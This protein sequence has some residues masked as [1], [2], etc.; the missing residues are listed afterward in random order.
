M[1][2]WIFSDLHTDGDPMELPSVAADAAVIA[3]DVGCGPDVLAWLKARF[4]T[5][6]T[7]Y[8][9]GNHEY[10]G[11]TLPSLR[12]EFEQQTQGSNIHVLENR[13]LVL[14]NVVFLGCTLWTDFEL[15]GRPVEPMKEAAERLNDFR[16]I[17]YVADDD[18][19]KYAARLEPLD[20]HFLHKAS[21]AWLH[22]QFARPRGSKK[23]VVVTHH[24]PSRRSVAERYRDNPLTP[25]FAS[26]LDDLVEH[27]GAALWIH[28]HV[29]DCFD[30]QLG[31]TRVLCNPRGYV[32]IDDAN[33]FDPALVVEV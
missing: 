4:P 24:A 27:S 11:F 8:V 20:T 12:K 14:G 10:Y 5:L 26:A 32:G 28:G 13:R 2:L 23:L 17:R 9:L 31:Q 33:G 22:K 16:R 30:Y 1:R 6:P 15:Y 21:V 7:I 25:A 3:G 29:H 19:D 18:D